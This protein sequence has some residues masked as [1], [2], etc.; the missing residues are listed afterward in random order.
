MATIK[1]NGMRCGH[2]SASVTRALQEIDGITDVRV[3]LEKG[4][5]S[6]TET[7]AVPPDT[8]R[9]AITKIGFEV[10]G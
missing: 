4:E 2:C 10:A 9:A 8:V 1:V 7:K 3:D 5:A 6:Y